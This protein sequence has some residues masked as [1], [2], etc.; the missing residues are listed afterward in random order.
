MPNDLA[1]FL[2]RLTALKNNLPKALSTEERYIREYHVVLDGLAKGTGE[3][4]SDFQVPASDVYTDP[5]TGER[6]YNRPFLMIK[7]D[8]VLG[9]FTFLLQPNEIKNE[10]GF[11]VERTD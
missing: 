4:L 1:K 5:E 6:F 2:A 7:L 10:L 8:G 11:K 9:Y 3:D